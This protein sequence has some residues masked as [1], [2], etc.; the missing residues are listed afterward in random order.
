MPITD[1]ISPSTL[2]MEGWVRTS[3]S[4]MLLANL[5]KQYLAQAGYIN[6]AKTRNVDLSIHKAAQIAGVTSPTLASY[7]K[8]GYLKLTPDGKL[9]LFDVL[10]F[11]YKLAKRTELDKKE[12]RVLN[13]RRK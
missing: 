9:N 7:I 12:R 13:V 1:Y 10:S 3:D 11:N 8:A 6:I 4:A 5:D 2:R